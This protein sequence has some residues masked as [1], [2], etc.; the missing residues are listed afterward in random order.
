MNEL[1]RISEVTSETFHTLVEERSAQ[2]PVL[3][4]FWAEWCGP[5]QM[6]MPVLQKLVEDY[7]GRFVIAK[8]NTDEQRE[9]AAAHGIRSLPTM[10]IYRNG[11]VVEEILGAQTE[12]TLRALLDRY[13][14]R[15]SDAVRVQARDLYAAGE[16]DRALALLQEARQAE[17]GNHHLA[18]EY[19]GLCFRAGRLDEAQA[20]LD[21]LPREAREEP[22]ALRLDALLGFAVD[23]PAD[24]SLA[25]LE[26]AV[27][28]RPDD[29]AARHRLASA[30]VL[31]GQYEPAQEAF[32]HILMHDRGFRDGA[33][34]KA[35]LALFSL[36][37]DDDERVAA[38][39]RRMFNALH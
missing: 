38:W 31:Q 37:G 34:R 30:R 6:Q 10:R 29:S 8:V 11:A 28:A 25:D 14:E 21:A 9:L 5:C 17:P 2:V 13:I 27:A 7:D 36:L 19:A 24:V 15:P 32:M 33:A 4:D 18:L 23:A 1:P 22:E 26:A 12:G 39:R 3:V 35:L 16:Q 20:L